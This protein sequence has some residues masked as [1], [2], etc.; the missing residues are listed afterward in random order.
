MK[1]DFYRNITIKKNHQA[2]VRSDV[3]IQMNRIED[4]G[5]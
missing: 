2:R 5:L 1:A 4:G 3:E